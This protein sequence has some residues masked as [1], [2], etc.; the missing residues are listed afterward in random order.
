MRYYLFSDL[1]ETLKEAIVPEKTDFLGLKVGPSLFTAFLVTLIVIIFCLAVKFIALPRF[2]KV[3]GR[4]QLFLEGLV[5]FFN[6]IAKESAH[7]YTGFIS[8]YIFAAASYI[9]L[10]TVIEMLGP[11]PVLGDINSCIALA[12]FTYGQ[13]IIY[14]VV[15]K[16]AIKGAFHSL[17]ESTVFVSF[18]FRLFGSIVSGFLIM[19]L[20]YSFIYLSFVLPAFLSVIFTL[21]HAF[22]QSY[23]FAMLSSLFF[24]EAIGEGELD[25]HAVKKAINHR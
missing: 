15:N 17:K 4:F 14:S 12:L 7:K 5:G 16:G 20:V 25:A 10:G 22:I 8:S 23:V 3:P 9:F 6:N 13:I 24:G 2:K 18:S 19:E 11:R 21:F 1:G